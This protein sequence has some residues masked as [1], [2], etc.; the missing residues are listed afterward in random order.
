M[1]KKLLVVDDE[2]RMTSSFKVIFE[3]KGFVVKTTSNGHEA[4]KIFKKH[5][6]KV[7]LSDIQMDKM[8]GIELM[9]KLKQIDPCVQIIFLTGYASIENAAKALK[10]NNV[11]DYLQKP[12]K[13]MNDLYKAVEDAENR[14][15]QEKYKVIQ[16]EKYEKGFAIFR[17]IFDSMEASVYVSDM[18]TYE[19][20]YANKKLL[21]TLGLKDD[22]GFKGQKCWQVFYKDQEGPCSFCTNKRLLDPDG[23]PGDPYEWEF[24]NEDNHRYYNI[25]DK[26]IKWYDNRIVRLETAFDITEKKEHEK[27]FRKFEKAIERSKKLESIGTLA[28]GV[29]HDFNNTLSAIIGN[30]NLAQFICPDNETQKY[31]RTAEAGVLQAKAISSKLIDFASGGTLVKAK[32]DI[33]KFIKQ[34]TDKY[35]DNGKIAC[36]IETDP[37][38]C[39]VYADSV[40]LEIAIK[41]ILKNSVESMDGKGSIAIAVKYIEQALALPRISISIKD[42]GCGIFREHLDMIFNPYFTT[43][44]LDNKKSTGLGL[45]VAWSIITRHGGDIRVESATKQGTMVEISLPIIG[46][47]EIEEKGKANVRHPIESVWDKTIT[48]VLVMDDDLLILNIISELLERLGYETLAASNSDQAIEIC[49][50]AKSS[51]EMI[52]IAL[53]DFEIQGGLGGFSTMERLMELDPAIRG[54]LITGHVDEIEIMNYRDFGFFDVLEKPFSIKQLNKKIRKILHS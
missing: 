40:Q 43:K 47:N 34:I 5:P 4:A 11:F 41:N 10:Q 14:Y 53:I 2:P 51:G 36:S 17:S 21:E 23:N 1:N 50:T 20:M 7:V 38:P 49:K 52:D 12:V 24:F 46:E 28:G 22:M 54:L 33:D 15:D 3:S 30:I 16:K 18:K 9:H 35:L 27:L 48:R 37:I 39:P 32:V 42:S 26:A 6:F 8:D 19:I 45:S 13:N 29:A 25:V 44:P 31:L